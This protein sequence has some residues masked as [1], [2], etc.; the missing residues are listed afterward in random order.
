MREVSERLADPGIYASGADVAALVA[1]YEI[2]TKRVRHLE[3]K[4]EEAAGLLEAQGASV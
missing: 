1:D 4:W 2:K 3:A